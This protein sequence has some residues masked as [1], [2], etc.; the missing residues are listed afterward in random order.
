AI[1][2]AKIGV[3]HLPTLALTEYRI[4]DVESGTEREAVIAGCGLDAR[5]SKTCFE[6][7][8]AVRDGI[9]SAAARHRNPVGRDKFMQGVQQVHV[10]LFE[11]VLQTKSDVAVPLSD[12]GVRLA[13]F[14]E[15]LYKAVGV[16]T[17]D[18][19]LAFIA[20]LHSL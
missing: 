7:Q 12:L 16:K 11:N 15:Y 10:V 4:A 9:K 2:V 13:R 1:F 6:K 8:L 19:H 20:Y 5:F 18:D 17:M 14:A 3:F